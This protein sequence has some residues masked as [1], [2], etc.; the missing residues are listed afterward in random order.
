[1]YIYLYICI[2]I[3]IYINIFF[4]SSLYLFTHLLYFLLFIYHNMIVLNST[5]LFY[6]KDCGNISSIYFYLIY[7]GD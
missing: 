7:F 3:C 5:L 4:F 1:M 6:T 2:Y